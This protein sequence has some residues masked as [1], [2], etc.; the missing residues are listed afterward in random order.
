MNLI[1][2]PLNTND[3]KA[4]FEGFKLFS[5]MND[6]YSF[7]WKEGMSYE[8]HLKILDDQ[9]HERNLAPH[10]VPASMLYA[11]LDGVIVGRASIRHRLN[12]SLRLTGGH[13][14][15][16]VATSYR[17][18]GIATEIL[19]QS[20]QHCREVLRMGKVLVTCDDDNI[21]SF[22]TIEKNNGILENCIL[23]EG[24]NVAK[25]RYWIKL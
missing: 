15:Y 13:I 14:G 24:S 1:L 7:V 5:D 17:R 4:F 9:F 11:F 3:E 12:E 19:R 22:K 23:P 10:L 16:A 8:D 25:R 20:L 18:R 21:G 6:W 2:R